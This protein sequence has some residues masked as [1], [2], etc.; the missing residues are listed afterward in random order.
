MAGESTANPQAAANPWELAAL[1]LTIAHPE[2][3]EAIA[4]QIGTGHFVNPVC[5]RIF[6]TCCRLAD[7]GVA[8]SFD[9]LMLE[10]D[11][12]AIQSLLVGIDETAQATG[13]PSA[14]P[15]ALLN[16]LMETF[17]RKEIERQRPEQIGAL[18]EGGLDELQQAQM[19]EEIIR[20]KRQA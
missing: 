4:R 9:R 6:E 15:V 18:R 5:R 19:L 14:D 16:G 13:Q 2:S 12:P 11:A 20:Q 1:Q 8:P 7:H 3:F 10:F 17:Q